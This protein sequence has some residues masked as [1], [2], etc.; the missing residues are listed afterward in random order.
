MRSTVRTMALCGVITLA[1]VGGA[2]AQSQQGGLRA[3]HEEVVALRAQVATLQSQLQALATLPAQMTDVQ[4]TLGCMSKVGNDVVFEGCNVHVRSGSGST[5]G[6]LNGLGNLV[7]GYSEG[8]GIADR[9]GSHNLV[10]GRFHEYSSWG[11]FLAGSSNSV[12]APGASV[13]GGILNK[14]HGEHSIV[15]G[16]EVNTA[17]GT[18]SSVSGGT[19]NTASG[20]YASVGGGAGNV[21]SGFVASV[22][23]GVDNHA[24]G[25]RAT[26]SGGRARSASATDSWVAGSLFEP[27]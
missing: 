12:T 17:D 6:V 23:G 7:V 18:R 14:A 3:L 19:G 10:V 4:S 26:V 20:E 11:G 13:C 15:S 1:L 24:N 27:N 8:A 22:N 5:D 21:A 9:S 25:T 16:G 2:D